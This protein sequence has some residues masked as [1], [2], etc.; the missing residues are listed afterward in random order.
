MKKN[1]KLNDSLHAVFCT[2]FAM[3]YENGLPVEEGLILLSEQDSEINYASILTLYQKDHNLM[4]A[5][6]GVNQF[7]QLLISSLE[8]AVQIGKE[9]SILKHLS[10]FY[11]RKSNIREALKELLTM[12]FILFSLLIIIL[13]VLSLIIL[14]IFQS[15]FINLGGSYPV[16]INILLS[17]LNIFS[18]VGLVLLVLFVIWAIFTSVQKMNHP[19][20][21][22]VIDSILNII[23]KN[24]YKADLAYFTYLVEIMNESGVN[25]QVALDLIFDYLPKRELY[26]HLKEV[27]LESNDNIIDLI[28][29]SK[30]YPS[31][32]Q[33]SIRIAYKSGNLEN[34]LKQVSKEAQLE[35]DKWIE[36]VFN[37][38]EPLVLF[39]L[40]IGVGS[41]LLALI[42][43]LLQAMQTLGL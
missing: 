29:K 1:T 38:I 22:D 12:P 26:R 11:S 28:L 32:T 39:I 24:A 14:P 23:P 8:I 42:I 34:T 13:N 16:W 31:F 25:Q 41:V 33:N 15:I 18:T 6:A 35:S 4:N 37:R 17:I 27:K 20:K 7:D 21:N 10:L 30:I 2:Q 5:L 36:K 19:E 43:P 9:E 3:I 40:A